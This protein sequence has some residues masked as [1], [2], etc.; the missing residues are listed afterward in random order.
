MKSTYLWLVVISVLLISIDRVFG[1]THIKS[2]AR[3]GLV[4]ASVG[5]YHIGDQ[6]N[7]AV[8]FIG[9]LP[10]A[11]REN[12]ELREEVVELSSFLVELDRLREENRALKLQ[13]GVAGVQRDPKVLAAVLGFKEWGDTVR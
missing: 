3:M 9:G 8:Q 6:T 4:P 11:Y 1:L 13:L 7:Q 12:S 2:I 10:H 5:L